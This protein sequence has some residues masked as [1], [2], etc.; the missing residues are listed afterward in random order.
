M[1]GKGRK[2][3]DMSRFFPL[4]MMGVLVFFLCLSILL[5]RWKNHFQIGQKWKQAEL[6]KKKGASNPCVTQ[7]CM[8]TSLTWFIICWGGRVSSL[9]IF[10]LAF[11]IIISVDDMWLY[12]WELNIWIH[13]G[14]CYFYISDLLIN[15]LKF[16]MMTM[17]H[18]FGCCCLVVIFGYLFVGARIATYNMKD[19]QRW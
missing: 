6:L 1:E 9:C 14:L 3:T 4:K 13:S 8:Y 18:A 19:M 2:R 11:L 7:G 17:T 12:L 15:N 10:Y 5:L 16:G